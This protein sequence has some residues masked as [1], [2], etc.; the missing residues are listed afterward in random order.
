MAVPIKILF[1][2]L[3]VLAVWGRQCNITFANYLSPHSLGKQD[4]MTDALVNICKQVRINTTRY[5]FGSANYTIYNVTTKCIYNDGKQ[6][7]DI[8]SGDKITMYGGFIEFQLWFNFS[9]SRIGP[10]K[11]GYAYGTFSLMQLPPSQAS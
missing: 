2:A 3:L 9:V 4:E 8:L 7:A 10:D 1:A 5:G 11:L 6:Q